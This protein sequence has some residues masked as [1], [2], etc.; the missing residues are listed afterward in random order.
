MSSILITYSKTAYF[1]ITPN[2]QHGQRLICSHKECQNRGVRFLFCKFCGV[3]VA[4]KNFA[5]RHSHEGEQGSRRSSSETSS[6]AVFDD[7][8]G[9]SRNLKRRYEQINAP[10]QQAT[11]SSMYQM[12][13]N[14]H[15]QQDVGAS[16]SA[17]LLPALGNP[18]ATLGNPP[19]R[20]EQLQ[21]L[22]NSTS[23]EFSRNASFLT[24]RN[25]QVANLEPSPLDPVI[26]EQLQLIR[27]STG[28]QV[29]ESQL[30]LDTSIHVLQAIR[31]HQSQHSHGQQQSDG[32]AI[33]GGLSSPLHTLNKEQSKSADPR[34]A[35]LSDISSGDSSS[36]SATKNA[37][38]TV[39]DL[40]RKKWLQLLETRPVPSEVDG[41][42]NDR[43]LVSWLHKILEVSDPRNLLELSPDS[44]AGSP[45][46]NDISSI[47]AVFAPS[48][49]PAAPTEDGS[50][51][52]PPST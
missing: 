17:A 21:S 41:T 39:R 31:M 5:S 4:S 35:G 3:P 43:E 44:K 48:A 19:T 32:V 27:S 36:L 47:N 20:D 8:A 50:E 49:A 33:A 16:T 25:Q 10:L 38:E 40:R 13:R 23:L 34:E 14:R 7:G 2:V 52:P 6:G 1:I 42:P 45:G 18:L 28:R 22:N 29:T 26:A 37:M 15:S 51:V 12:P 9:V 46:G 30:P 24:N 11:S